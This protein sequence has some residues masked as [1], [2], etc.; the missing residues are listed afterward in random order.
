MFTYMVK[1]QNFYIKSD[2][3]HGEVNSSNL[4]ELLYI[5]L[6]NS[7]NDTMFLTWVKSKNMLKSGWH[8]SICDEYT[9]HDTNVV[10]APFYI[11]PNDSTYL[12]GH[13]IL[14]QI[15]GSGLIQLTVYDQSD[16][17]NSVVHLT[18]TIDVDEFTSVWDK[19]SSTDMRISPNP[20]KGS[21]VL[22]ET[23]G[24]DQKITV[25]NSRGM[26][27]F[28][29]FSSPNYN[30]EIILPPDIRNGLYFLEVKSD[31]KN[32]VSKFILSR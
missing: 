25:Y 20:N 10:T 24:E 17:V 3:V 6:Y 8:S 23:T 1:G 16:S 4:A 5:Y 29:T 26:V 14:N 19:T 11:S 32:L 13:F 22:S 15:K 9:C 27:V 7:T 12:V 31:K 21:F 2:S 18:Y 30:T 28:E